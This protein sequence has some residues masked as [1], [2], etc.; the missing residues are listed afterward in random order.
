MP[1]FVKKTYPLEIINDTMYE[2]IAEYPIVNVLN[3]SAIKKW[4]GVDA[5]FKVN[6]T[7]SYIFCNEVQDIE[8][9][10]IN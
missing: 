7:G 2:I 8:W 1:R 3:A 10:E 4:L 6:R 9:E 5:A